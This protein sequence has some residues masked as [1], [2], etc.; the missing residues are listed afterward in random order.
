M[1]DNSVCNFYLFF[2]Q[3]LSAKISLL[4]TLHS[5]LTSATVLSAK[6]NKDANLSE[7]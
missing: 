2:N 7:A 5:K 1:F 4:S 3:E 6:H